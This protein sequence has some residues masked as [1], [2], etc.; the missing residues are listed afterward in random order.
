M[1]VTKKR[2]LRTPIPEFP[3]KAAEARFGIEYKHVYR[4]E[5][6]ERI[7]IFSEPLCRCCFPFKPNRRSFIHMWRA[8]KV[9]N[10]FITLSILNKRKGTATYFLCAIAV[11]LKVNCM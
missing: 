4:K 9:N 11:N 6:S 5:V 7:S 1:Y 2:A 8:G 3:K 10:S